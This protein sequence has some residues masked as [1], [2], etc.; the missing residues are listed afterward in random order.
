MPSA[1]LQRAWCDLLS[2][3]SSARARPGIDTLQAARWGRH[4]PGTNPHAPCPASSPAPPRPAQPRRG[5]LALLLSALLWLSSLPARLANRMLFAAQKI[6][7]AP[8]VAVKLAGYFAVGAPLV[9][10]AGLLYRWVGERASV[11][12]LLYIGRALRASPLGG[13]GLPLFLA[14]WPG[15]A[16]QG[17]PAAFISCCCG[18][19][20]A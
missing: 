13:A 14:K 10:G 9:L 2:W 1:G 16:S 5:P 11:S 3:Y 19:N 20:Q 17:A 15:A 6:M 18:N 7:T 12:I 8:S 4:A